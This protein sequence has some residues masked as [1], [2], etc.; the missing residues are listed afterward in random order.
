[1]TMMSFITSRV[2]SPSAWI[3]YRLSPGTASDVA[4]LSIVKLSSVAVPP[5]STADTVVP[6]SAAPEIVTAS[7]DPGGHMG[8]QST[9]H[10]P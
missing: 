10:P 9:D 2:V 7:D 5:R 1:M 8:V 4:L 3:A 6:E